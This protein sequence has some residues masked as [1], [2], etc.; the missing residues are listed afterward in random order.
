MSASRSHAFSISRPHALPPSRSY[1]LPLSQLHKD[2]ELDA[3]PRITVLPELAD[4]C[5][6]VAASIHVLSHR[7]VLASRHIAELLPPPFDAYRIAVVRIFGFARQRQ[8]VA[9]FYFLPQLLTLVVL[10]ARQR[11]ALHQHPDFGVLRVELRARQHGGDEQRAA[12]KAEH[13]TGSRVNNQR[14]APRRR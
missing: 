1:A 7:L 10:K 13:E 5:F 9:D 12:Q 11:R 4:A 2:F 6:H 14:R 8:G 3:L